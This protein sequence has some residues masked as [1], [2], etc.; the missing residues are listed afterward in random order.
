MSLVSFSPAAL[1]DIDQIWTYTAE[2]WGLDQADR[3]VDDIHNACLDLADGVKQGRQVDVRVGYLKYAIGRHL[4][5]YRLSDVGISVVRV[6]H[7][8]MDVDRHL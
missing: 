7:Q 6:L 4:I 8:S 3:Y 1:S 2:N 5:F